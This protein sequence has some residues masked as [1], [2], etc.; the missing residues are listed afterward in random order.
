MSDFKMLSTLCGTCN[1]V[2]YG[3]WKSIVYANV[4]Y[5]SV[6]I[7]HNPFRSG[8]MQTIYM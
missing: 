6:E 8:L 1:M 4:G 3:K 2:K 5:D 7:L